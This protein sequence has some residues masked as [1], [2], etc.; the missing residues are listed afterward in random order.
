MDKFVKTSDKETADRL[1]AEGLQLVC[2]D[3]SC[4]VFVND[5]KKTAKF[6][7]EKVVFTSILA[8]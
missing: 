7:K 5:A 2:R 4:W 6:K 3:N 1:E 8:I